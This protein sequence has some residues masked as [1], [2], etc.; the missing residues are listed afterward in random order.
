M[1]KAALALVTEIG[2]APQIPLGQLL[3]VTIHL[4]PIEPVEQILE[5]GTQVKTA[6]ATRAD[7]EDSLELLLNSPFLPKGSRFRIK[8]HPAI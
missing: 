1:I 5:G 3:R 7:V 6:P 4:V 2:D 8:T